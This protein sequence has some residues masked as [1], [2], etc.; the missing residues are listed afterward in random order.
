MIGAFRSLRG[1]GCFG[2][3]PPSRHMAYIRKRKTGWRVE[4]ER[5]GVRQSQTF[6]TKAA[7]EAWARQVES[8]LLARKRGALP[9]YSVLQAL[10]KYAQEVS[11]NKKGGAWEVK[12]LT[13]FGREPWA[14]KLLQDLTAAD[15]AKWRDH[16]LQGVT[17]GSVRRDLTVLRSVFKLAI[18]EW[19][20]I[21]ASPLDGLTIPAENKPRTRRIGWRE[22]RRQCRA[23]G[24]RTG[25]VATKQQEVALA[26]LIG[27]RTAMRAGEILSLT[28]SA[29][30]I[31]SRVAHLVDTKNGEDRD[32]PLSRAAI[33][34]LK[35][36]RGWTVDSAS[37]DALFRKARV[38]AGL[39]G[40]TFHDSRAEALT[41]MSSKLDPF[42]LARVSGHKDMGILLSR[43]YRKS[44]SEIARKLG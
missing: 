36:W 17:P 11:P 5:L 2:I 1:V 27:L 3:P 8:D 12:R 28:P 20:W 7:G 24:Y 35:S 39:S 40:F 38:R 41:R 23:L 10:E 15:L 34:L 37:L 26:F 44:A 13:A 30:D 9:R 16:R 22:I 25:Q 18:R 19:Q 21:D 6:A 29:V 4:V 31:E 32:V 33:R 43:Y 14:G 42:E